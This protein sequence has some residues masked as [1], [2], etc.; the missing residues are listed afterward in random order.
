MQRDLIFESTQ[1]SAIASN[2][3]SRKAD[4]GRVA[5]YSGL[6]AEEIVNRHYTTRGYQTLARRWRGKAG[7][8]DLICK[9]ARGYVFVEI[10]KSSSFE[11]ASHAFQDRQ[12]RRIAS[13]AEEFLGRQ[14]GGLQNEMRIDLA[15]VDRAGRVQIVENPVW[16]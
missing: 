1:R 15:L 10:K 2:V 9:D 11:R 3:N 7:E 6:A 13:A 16:F 8:I 12:A 14:K 5:Y 4:K